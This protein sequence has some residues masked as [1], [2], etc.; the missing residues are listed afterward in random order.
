[1]KIEENW[2]RCLREVVQRCVRTDGQWMASDQNS[3]L[4]EPSAQ[5]S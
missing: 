5:V 3:S 2:P 1:M 4:A